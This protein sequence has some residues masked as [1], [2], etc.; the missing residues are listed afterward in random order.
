MQLG[1]I[2]QQN[3]NLRPPIMSDWPSWINFRKYINLHFKLK[4]IVQSF[5][6]KL[7]RA[8]LI[9]VSSVIA[10]VYLFTEET[11]F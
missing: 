8:V 7:V 2:L 3:S 9:I 1:R 10:T 4:E 6:F 5:V 11:A